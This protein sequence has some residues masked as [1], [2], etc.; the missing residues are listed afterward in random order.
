MMIMNGMAL[1]ISLG[2]TSAILCEA[3]LNPC[4]FPEIEYNVI[5]LFPIGTYKKCFHSKKTPVGA[6]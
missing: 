6:S 3:A 5:I 1:C 2:L 4:I